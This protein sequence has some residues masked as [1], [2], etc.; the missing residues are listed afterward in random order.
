MREAEFVCALQEGRSRVTVLV[1]EPIHSGI[2]A[3]EG[4]RSQVV[5]AFFVQSVSRRL[6]QPANGNFLRVNCF[7]LGFRSLFVNTFFRRARFGLRTE[8]WS[9]AS[10]TRV[11]LPLLLAGGPS[12]VFVF[13]E[14]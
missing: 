9:E 3:T 1:C 10:G 11:S 12:V 7:R 14:R 2:S 13:Q 4:D 8:V 5:S 6:Q